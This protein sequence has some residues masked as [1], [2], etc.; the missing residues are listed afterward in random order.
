MTAMTTGIT[1]RVNTARLERLYIRN[2]ESDLMLRDQEKN[3]RAA[4]VTDMPMGNQVALGFNAANNKAKGGA[5]K[6]ISLKKSA[7]KYFDD[8]CA[9][10][11]ASDIGWTIEYPNGMPIS[12][13]VK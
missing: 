1:S 12:P 8:G 10:C 7:G 9:R 11:T 5:S 13:I 6:M 4:K 2:L 3:T